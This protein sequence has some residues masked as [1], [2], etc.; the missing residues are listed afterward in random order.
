MGAVSL[1]G[2]CAPD[3]PRSTEGRS[4]TL[5]EVAEALNARGRR[6]YAQSVANIIE[7]A[8][9]QTQSL[10]GRLLPARGKPPGLIWVLRMAYL[11]FS[12]DLDPRLQDWRLRWRAAAEL[13]RAVCRPKVPRALRAAGVSSTCQ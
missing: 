6:W 3:H 11:R 13:R 9:E 12:N 10:I 7:R 8:K 2:Q 4:R 5:R 1:R